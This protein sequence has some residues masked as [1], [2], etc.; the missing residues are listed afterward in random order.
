MY[1]N[2]YCKYISLTAVFVSCD[3]IDSQYG[4]YKAILPRINNIMSSTVPPYDVTLSKMFLCPS[5]ADRLRPPHQDS[6]Y[7]LS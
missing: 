4:T 2:I 1:I 7:D 3:R 5:T 6:Y